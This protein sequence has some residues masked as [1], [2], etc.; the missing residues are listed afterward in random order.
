MAPTGGAG[1][2]GMRP[3]HAGAGLIR[4]VPPQ[5]DVLKRSQRLHLQAAEV[6]GIAALDVFAELVAGEVGVGVEAEEG[7]RAERASFAR[8][9]QK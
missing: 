5:R 4:A 6:H 7:H 9:L 3:S 1:A 8:S 2:V